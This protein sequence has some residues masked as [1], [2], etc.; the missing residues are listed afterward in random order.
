VSLLGPEPATDAEDHLD[1][2]VRGLADIFLG[3]E[4]SYRPM[5]RLS[6]QPRAMGQHRP[7][8]PLAPR[9]QAEHERLLSAGDSVPFAD[10]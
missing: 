4:E 7:H 9:T 6:L 10:G 1:A 8:H 2:V 3:A 5:P